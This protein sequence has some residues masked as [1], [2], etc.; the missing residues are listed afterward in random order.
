ME[1]VVLI[2]DEMGEGS[3]GDLSYHRR[4][5]WEMGRYKKDVYREYVSERSHYREMKV[6]RFMDDIIK[7]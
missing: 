1:R 6:S 3:N 4:Q 5:R 2:G 7:S